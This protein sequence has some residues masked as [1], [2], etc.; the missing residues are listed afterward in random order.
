MIEEVIK[1][2]NTGLQGIDSDEKII[3][4]TQLIWR[5]SGAD[6][7]DYLPGV[8]DSSGEAIYAGI[9][10][11]NSIMLYHRSNA[12]QLSFTRNSGGYGDGRQNEDVIS[13]SLISVWDTRKIQTEKADMLLLLRSR[14]PQ[15]IA[16][17]DGINQIVITPTGALLNTKQIFE[18]EYKMQVAYL[19]PNFI[20]IIQLNY[21]IQ[22]KY[23]PR[24]IEK[25]INCKN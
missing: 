2:I 24:C 22:F 5:L 18:S 11:V 9:D 21:N 10:D 14:I 20:N 15:E 16:G 3:G 8:V 25:C 12:A 1:L 4:L 13:F 19:L 7:V 23:D 17:I 6:K